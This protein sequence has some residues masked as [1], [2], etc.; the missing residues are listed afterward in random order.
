MLLDMSMPHLR[1]DEVYRA[2]AAAAQRP[3][4]PY[5]RLQRPARGRP[6]ARGSVPA[7]VVDAAGAARCGVRRARPGV[8]SGSF[9]SA[10]VGDA[11]ASPLID[12]AA[13]LPRDVAAAAHLFPVLRRLPGFD[14]VDEVKALPPNVQRRH[15][16]AALAELLARVA[17]TR[18]LAFVLDDVHW[19][20]QDSAELPGMT[21]G[22]SARREGQR[23]GHLQAQRRHRGRRQL[24]R[25]GIRRRA[26]AC[27]ARHDRSADQAP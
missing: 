6:Q 1:G 18:P 20:D 2:A 21:G 11:R 10:D 9:A 27:H 16:A 25:E 14:A 15:G 24:H 17:V 4:G 13:V 19:G 23:Q 7:E 26:Q 12:A 5:E 22:L 8:S 3:R